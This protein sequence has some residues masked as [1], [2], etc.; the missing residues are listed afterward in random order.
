MMQPSKHAE[1]IIQTYE[2]FSST[3]YK[4][5]ARVLTIGYGHTQ[6]VKKGDVCSKEQALI[7]LRQD[8]SEVAKTVERLVTVPLT[9]NQ[10]DALCCF[11]FNVGAK[12]FKT[13]NLLK[14]LNKGDYQGAANQF[15]RWVYGGDQ[16]SDGKVN[17]KDA[18]AGL[19]KRRKAE[20]DLFL[21]ED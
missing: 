2:G 18:L 3:A 4:C 13:S 12:K 19:V 8:L 14:K 1:A 16:N 15:S 17:S 7:Y 11:V 6:G 21:S 9:Q 10:F 20:K 5:P